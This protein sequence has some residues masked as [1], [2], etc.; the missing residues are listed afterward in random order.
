[1]ERSSTGGFTYAGTILISLTV[2]MIAMTID[3]LPDKEIGYFSAAS[4]VVVALFMALKVRV[5]DLTAA[6]W[7]PMLVWFGALMTA[8]QIARP[9][10]GSTKERELVLILH[11]LA[12]HAWWILGATAL[13]A[14][15]VAIR[16][17]R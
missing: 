5:T 9:R 11:G 12:D 6:L 16:R 10:A 1:M 17:F 14:V 15:V 3:A 2:M 7:S 8:G 4:L 13:A